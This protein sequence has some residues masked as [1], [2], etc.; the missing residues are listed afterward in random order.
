MKKEYLLN[1]QCS[2]A[3]FSNMNDRFVADGYKGK[4]ANIP[5]EKQC[6]LFAEI[7]GVG[8]IVTPLIS[9]VA[10]F[11][12]VGFGAFGVVASAVAAVVGIIGTLV[13]GFV[14]AGGAVI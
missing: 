14:S 12:A 6:E 9:A 11:G 3:A 2:G 5:Y 7:G 13:G 8:A 1:L 10:S 4:E